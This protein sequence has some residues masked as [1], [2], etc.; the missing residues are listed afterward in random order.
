[1]GVHRFI[2]I[3]WFCR[4]PREKK[5]CTQDH[6]GM[7]DY[8]VRLLLDYPLLAFPLWHSWANGSIH[9]HS[10]V[11]LVKMWARC[12]GVHWGAMPAHAKSHATPSKVGE[13]LVRGHKGGMKCWENKLMIKA[14]LILTMDQTTIMW[15]MSLIVTN[16]QRITTRFCSSPQLYGASMVTQLIVLVVWPT[17]SLS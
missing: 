13:Y 10:N 5:I 12:Q 11:S 4:H 8:S 16:A 2:M 9:S 17:T 15:K 1:M 6:V 7:L 3:G 14:A